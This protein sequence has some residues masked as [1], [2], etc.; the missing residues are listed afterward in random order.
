[1]GA[2]QYNYWSQGWTTLSGAKLQLS[3]CPA[4][5]ASGSVDSGGSAYGYQTSCHYLVD[6]WGGG[7]LRTLTSHHQLLMFGGGHSDSAD[8][9]VYSLNYN[10]LTPTVTRIT[11]PNTV[12]AANYNSC[13]GGLPS[14]S[15]VAPNS[16]HSYARNTYIPSLDLMF[17][18][19]G[20]LYCGN[21]GNLSDTW[22]FNPASP[23][24][25]S[26][27]PTSC[28]PGSC[29][30]SNGDPADIPTL[31]TSVSGY[32]V[33]D[34]VRDSVVFY[35]GNGGNA[36]EYF[37]TANAYNSHSNQFIV[38]NLGIGYPGDVAGV[39]LDTNRRIMWFVGSAKVA[40]LVLSTWTY[41]DVTASVNANCNGLVT[42]WWSYGLFDESRYIVVLY[43]F[44]FWWPYER[45]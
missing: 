8:N 37:P 20:A 38:R 17:E 13:V 10:L 35:V 24:W 32:T 43:Y 45:R 2:I 41:T 4:N 21:G 40:K 16:R 31:T 22:M 18:T 25:A 28:A 42:Q 7:A 39:A 15:P 27:E 19:G 14:A 3:I 23:S 9:S 34:P 29:G 30:T 33:Y 6:A 44:A 26:K 12:T 5:G 36:F 11:N 1:M